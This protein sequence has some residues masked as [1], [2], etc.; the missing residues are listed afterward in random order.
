MQFRRTQVFD[1][2][3]CV[4]VFHADEIGVPSITRYWFAI[5]CCEATTTKGVPQSTLHIDNR[6]AGG[7]E[8]SVRT[9]VE[10][11]TARDGPAHGLQ[12]TCQSTTLAAGV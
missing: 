9:R 6:I 11:L 8:R 5:A 3:E 1:C 10:T 4:A 12:G 7:V 2:L